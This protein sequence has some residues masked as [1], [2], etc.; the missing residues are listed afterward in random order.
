VE[1]IA[2]QLIIV[3]TIWGAHRYTPTLGFWSAFAWSIGTL[4]VLSYAPSIVVQIGIIWGTYFG[5]RAHAG[6]SAS[7]KATDSA[8][9][10]RSEAPD[11]NDPTTR[12]A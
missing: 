11:G 7:S 10:D 6:R 3:A 9:S 2:T 12:G 8:I 5:L 1:F 4:A